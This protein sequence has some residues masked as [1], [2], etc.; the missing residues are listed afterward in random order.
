[1]G[2]T[3]HLSERDAKMLSRKIVEHLLKLGAHVTEIGVHLELEGFYFRATINGHDVWV[4][5]GQGNFRYERVA[6]ELLNAALH[7]SRE[8]S[9]PDLEIVTS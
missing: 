5:T 7:H 1:M 8:F 2:P 9:H 4:R 6:A 3:P